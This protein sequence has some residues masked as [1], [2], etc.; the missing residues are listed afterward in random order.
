MDEGEDAISL[1]LS[2]F[3]D[4]VNTFFDKSWYVN[5]TLPYNELYANCLHPAV[6]SVAPPSR[7]VELPVPVATPLRLAAEDNTCCHHST[8]AECAQCKGKG[9]Q[10]AERSDSLWMLDSGASMHFTYSMN[11]YADFRYYGARRPL[12]TADGVTYMIGEGTVLVPLESGSIL[13]L[14]NV[15]LVPN[16]TSK[17]VSMGALLQDG[18]EARAS[19]AN[20]SFYKDSK[21]IVAFE[22]RNM[23]DTIYVTHAQ[24]IVA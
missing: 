5:H 24:P 4:E 13:K 6:T 14:T 11:D 9:K 15:A 21:L 20:I 1:G 2:D 7:H 18:L 17:L 19:T 10:P 23:G 22:P 8:L 12:Y 16:L 3:E